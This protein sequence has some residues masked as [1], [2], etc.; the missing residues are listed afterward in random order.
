MFHR[1][2]IFLLLILSAQMGAAQDL[3][4]LKVQAD[5]AF[6]AEEYKRAAELYSTIAKENPSE[7]IC[8]N[9]GC[10]YYRLDNMAQSVLWFERA[11]LLDP[12]DED[13]HFNLEMARSKTI[14][15]IT[16]RHEMFFVTVYRSVVNMLSIKGWT[17][18]A[19]SLFALCLAC[20]A[21]YFF[22]S[23]LTLRKV[24]FF[25]TIL[26]FVM[27]ILSNVF[28]LQQ[29]DYAVNRTSAIILSPAITVKSTPSESGND[30]FVLHEG[31]KVVIQDN[32]I[33]GWCEVRVADGK[34][35][36]ITRKSIECI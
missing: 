28:A 33:K 18:L 5:S 16:P 24:A 10:T 17:W 2:Y 13:I 20:F 8:Y 32:S 35:G 23:R 30:L 21:I 14:D 34:V 11:S 36:W 22:S 26:L 12:S 31:T 9:L 4:Q 29:R 27:V 1:L 3:S 25:A 7:E 15:K 19:M 6:A